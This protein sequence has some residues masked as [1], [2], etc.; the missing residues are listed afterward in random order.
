MLRYFR[1]NDPYRLVALLVLLI[2]IYLPLFLDPAPV[3]LPELRSI[4]VG[5]KIH[6]GSKMYAQIADPTGPLSAWVHGL[7]DLLFGRSLLARH[8]LA[9]ILIFLQSAY[10]GIIFIT[11]KAFNENTFIPSLIYSSLFFF[12]FDTIALSDELLG[13]AFLLFALNNL[14][15]EIEFRMPRDE[16]TFNLGICISLASLFYLPYVVFLFGVMI[17]LFLFART[18]ARKFFLLIFGFLLPHLFVLSLHYLQDSADK[19]WYHYYASGLAFDKE[20]LVSTKGIVILSS[21]GIFYLVVSIVMLNRLARFSKYQ[22]QLLQTIF[23]WIG[24]CFIYFLF[25]RDIRPQTLIVLIPPLTFLFTN[26]LLLIRRRKFAEM[27]TFLL[28]VGIVS[29]SYFARYGKLGGVDYSRLFVTAPAEAAVRGKKILVLGDEVGYY[30]QN[31]PATPFVNWRQS[32]VVFENPDYYESVTEVYEAFQNDP[33][34]HIIDK[35]N[36]MKPFL[37]RIPELRARYTRKGI[38]YERLK[39]SN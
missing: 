31:T 38:V 39:L 36:L 7:L 32:R 14:F 6:G 35:Q 11:K 3:T 28:L 2:A 12:S 16:T 30:L 34:D 33:P 17:I 8:I 37:E 21:V 29:I 1:I 15:K 20:F 13:S 27:N 10:L 18:D 4:L 25:C 24:F 22:S 19:I 9:F 23:L 5:E 26:F